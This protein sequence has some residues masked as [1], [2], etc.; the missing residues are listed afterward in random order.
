MEGKGLRMAQDSILWLYRFQASYC[1]HLWCHLCHGVWS[2]RVLIMQ[3]CNQCAPLTPTGTA[4]YLYRWNLLHTA[5]LVLA[6]GFWT[7]RYSPYFSGRRMPLGFF[8]GGRGPAAYHSKK[9]TYSF[10][11]GAAADARRGRRRTGT[12]PAGILKRGRRSR[13]QS[14]PELSDGMVPQ[15]MAAAVPMPS[16]PELNAMFA[17]MVVSVYV[18]LSFSLA[19]LIIVSSRV[20]FRASGIV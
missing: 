9:K 18:L 10:S 7:E 4:R 6:K 14:F 8:G 16:E 11:H 13:P 1:T 3:L 15:E 12:A 20:Y 17:Q 2:W 5:L 19:Q